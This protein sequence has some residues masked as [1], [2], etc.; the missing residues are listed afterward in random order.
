MDK[1]AMPL[2]I[3]QITH[4]EKSPPCLMTQ[5]PSVGEFFG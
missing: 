1:W 5:D 3:S 4:T 2:G